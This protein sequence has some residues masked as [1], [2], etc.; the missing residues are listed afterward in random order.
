MG[1]WRLIYN[2]LGYEYYGRKEQAEIDKQKHLKYLMCQEL[3]TPCIKTNIAP[4]SKGKK[5]RKRKK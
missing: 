5:K 4:C 2:I 3:L 1:V